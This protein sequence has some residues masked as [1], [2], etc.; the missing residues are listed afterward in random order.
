M[1]PLL[2]IVR[3]STAFLEQRGID[4]P[5]LNAEWLIAHALGLRRM[6]LYLQFERPLIE[7]ELARIRPLVRRRAQREPLAHILGTAEFAGLTLRTDRRALIPRPETEELVEHL[8]A[9][10]R[11][12]PARVLDLG[13]GTGAIALALA[14]AWPECRVTALDRS[15]EALALAR[16]NAALTA[17]ASRVE[18][19]LSDWWS[20]V[21]AAPRYPLIVSNPPYLSPAEFASAEPEVR[22]FEPPT[23]LVAQGEGLADF[24]TILTVAPAHLTPDGWLALET[25]PDQHPALLALAE[26]AGFAHRESIADLSGRP[27]FLLLSQA[28]PEPTTTSAAQ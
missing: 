12:P 23:A 1:Q 20:A 15:A 2:E 3:K 16:E 10:L 27:R 6:D 21:P 18:F 9:K 28:V 24:Q 13:T 19:L 11:P 8:V 26:A 17:L 14:R 4:Q 25:G 5:R 7:A 22:E